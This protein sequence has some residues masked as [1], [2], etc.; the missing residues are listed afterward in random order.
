MEVNTLHF[1][2]WPFNIINDLGSF[3]LLLSHPQYDVF[4]PLSYIFLVVSY[5]PMF[6]ESKVGSKEGNVEQ[7][8]IFLLSLIFHWD[9]KDL[10]WNLTP[11]YHLC[12][13]SQNWVIMATRSCKRGWGC[14]HFLFWNLG[15]WY[16]KGSWERLMKKQQEVF[17]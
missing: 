8:W 5:L 15:T 9:K 3:Y 10:S 11:N 7:G 12:H 13:I 4:D 14:K 1:I 16:K 6:Q 17:S 2:W